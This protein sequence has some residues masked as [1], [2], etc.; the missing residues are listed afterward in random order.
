MQGL[1]VWVGFRASVLCQGDSEGWFAN[2]PAEPNPVER[3]P[4]M[5]RVLPAVLLVV[6]AVT[7][8]GATRS[9]SES[10][11][12]AYFATRFAVMDGAAAGA[13]LV[14][15]GNPRLRAFV[16]GDLLALRKL[17]A[18]FPAPIS[19]SH[20]YTIESR[21]GLTY[22]VHEM[23]RLTWLDG[24]LGPKTSTVGYRHSITL[25]LT[26]AGSYVIGKDAFRGVSWDSPDVP[27]ASSVIPAAPAGRAPGLAATPARPNATIGYYDWNAATLYEAQW[28]NGRNPAYRDYGGVDCTNFVSQALYAGGEVMVAGGWAYSPAYTLAWVNVNAHRNWMLNNG[29]GYSASA[30]SSLSYGD[31]IYYQWPGDSIPNHA[32]MVTGYDGN[33]TRLVSMHSPE[34]GWVP[35]DSWPAPNLYPFVAYF[36]QMSASYYY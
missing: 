14:A 20:E 9:S 17:L 1:F 28:F 25:E 11:L 36:T 16:D 3:G 7:G 5:S 19:R 33:G 30:A 13:T 21:S 35:W 29:R 32:T 34:L 12:D 22:A 4:T 8:L 31:L 18:W 27:P 10:A 6:L 15:A 26:P 24:A 23:T 2:E